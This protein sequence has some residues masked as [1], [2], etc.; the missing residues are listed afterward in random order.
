[1]LQG[2]NVHVVSWECQ[3]HRATHSIPSI[4]LVQATS[5][6]GGG[7]GRGASWRRSPLIACGLPLSALLL[8]GLPT[9]RPDGTAALT[10]SRTTNSDEKLHSRACRRRV[11]AAVAPDGAHPGDA[12]LGRVW[13]AAERAAAQ[14]A[15]HAAPRRHGRARA[16]VRARAGGVRAAHHLVRPCFTP[17]SLE[18]FLVCKGVSGVCGGAFICV[19]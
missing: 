18:A 16:P 17:D 11:R 15:A 13:P 14:G 19:C 8:K 1:M 12:V 2:C 4:L 9:Q 10:L 6:R 7:P 3:K 5:A